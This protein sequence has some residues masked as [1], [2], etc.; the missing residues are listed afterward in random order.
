VF[1]SCTSSKEQATPL[2]GGNFKAAA[3]ADSQESIVL[4][5]A[6]LCCTRVPSGTIEDDMSENKIVRGSLALVEQGEMSGPMI[7]WPAAERVFPWDSPWRVS[8][9]PRLRVGGSD[10]QSRPA[11][12]RGRPCM[13]R[14]ARV[15]LGEQLEGAHAVVNLAGLSVI[16]AIPHGN[17][18]GNP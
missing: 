18:S 13:G 2:T 11:N 10:P 15:L 7:F 8:C 17:P 12:S 9:R 3:R 14:A 6:A 5:D 4:A 16:V 1:D